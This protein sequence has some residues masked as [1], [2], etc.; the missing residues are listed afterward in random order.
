MITDDDAQR[1]HRDATLLSVLAC[2][3]TLAAIGSAIDSRLWIAWPALAASLVLLIG[4]T[5]RLR[6]L[7]KDGH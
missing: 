6:H 7:Q 5:L 4:A 3:T 2:I 1:A